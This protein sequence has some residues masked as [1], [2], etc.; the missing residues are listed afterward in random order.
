MGEEIQEFHATGPR[1]TMRLT[2]AGILAALL[3][4]LQEVQENSIV[5]GE[6]LER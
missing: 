1:E 4:E 2:Q 6:I 3:V 5:I